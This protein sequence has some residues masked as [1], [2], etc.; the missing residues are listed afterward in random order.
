MELRKFT[1]LNKKITDLLED[2][3]KLK[4]NCQKLEERLK[5]KESALAEANE[6]IKGLEKERNAIR[7]KVDSLLEL[8]QDIQVPR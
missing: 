5:N 4:D 8:L 1:E 3:T 6:K 2:H 7:T